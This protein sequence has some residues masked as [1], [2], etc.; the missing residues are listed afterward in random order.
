MIWR[1]KDKKYTQALPAVAT[2]AVAWEEEQWDDDRKGSCDA[3]EVYLRFKAHHGPAV[4]VLIQLAPLVQILKGW[5]WTIG[6][7]VQ[8]GMG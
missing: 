1:Q 3:W 2:V 4:A 6:T 8:D 7:E 5:L